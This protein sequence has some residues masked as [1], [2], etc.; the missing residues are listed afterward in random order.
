M[1][2]VSFHPPLSSTNGEISPCP[3]IGNSEMASVMRQMDWAAT[4]LGPVKGWSSALRSAVSLCLGSR[5]CMA[6]YWGPDHLLLYN[7]A[8]RALLGARHPWALTRGVAEVW[9]EIAA[10]IQPWIRKT[11]ER[12]ITLGFDDAPLFIERSNELEEAYFS[13]SYT[14][15]VTDEGSIE[16][17][18]ATLPETTSK[19]VGERRLRTLQGLGFHT[20]FALQPAQ[21]L[22]AAAEVLAHNPYDVPFASFYLWEPEAETASLCALTG[23]ARDLPLSPP[24]LALSSDAPLARLI[25][26]AELCPLQHFDIPAALQ[27]VPASGWLANPRRGVALF[28]GSGA[29]NAP[30]AIM[31]AGLNPHAR[32]DD[33]YAEF[34]RMLSNA[35][36]RALSEAT[37]HAEDAARVRALRMR[38][39]LARQEERLRIARDLHDTLLQSVQGMR[40]LLEC[41]LE[42]ART[43]PTTAAELFERALN[44]SVNAI[45]EGRKVLSLLRGPAT[46]QSVVA[47]LTLLLNQMLQ[48]SPIRGR[49]RTRGRERNLNPDVREEILAVCREAVTNALRHADASQVSIEVCFGR[50]LRLEVRD[51]GRGVAAQEP[52]EQTE[53]YGL[54]GMRERAAAIG[55]ELTLVS[56]AGQGTTVRLGIPAAMAY[57]A[58]TDGMPI[59]REEDAG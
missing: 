16:G 3:F 35:I 50:R 29:A 36:S 26:Q 49:V 57:A 44:T 27:P 43:D 10:S 23:L 30:R 25:A 39:Q 22:T 42:R 45:E 53:H 11:Y 38:A 40:V 46:N 5:L 59:T 12:G 6:V 9:P 21:A 7:D 56:T 33:A 58:A 24:T 2:S 28:L 8:Y 37:A 1:G 19:V 52:P 20:R 31:I 47:A 51:D 32:L 54:R 17:V 14:P 34:F 15:I 18:F 13:F 4:A 48:R 41:G 55:A